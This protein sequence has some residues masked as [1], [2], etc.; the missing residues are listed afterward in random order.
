ML[1]GIGNAAVVFF[2]ELVGPPR[3]GITAL[4]ELPDERVAFFVRGQGQEGT[5]LGLINKVDNVLIQ[6]LSVRGT[7]RL[8]GFW[9][10][11]GGI[12][13]RRL[14][15]PCRDRSRT[16]NDE[17]HYGKKWRPRATGFR[18]KQTMDAFHETASC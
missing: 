15:R 5:A 2:F 17:N 10:R 16:G 8:F 7:E 1:I 11:R 12:G 6:P 4:P 3:S 14:R 9:L 18:I 13:L